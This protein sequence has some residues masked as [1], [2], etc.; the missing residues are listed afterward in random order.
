MNEPTSISNIY[1]HFTG[2]PKDV[3]W[4]LI[5]SPAQIPKNPKPDNEAFE[6]LIKII[7]S[8]KLKASATEKILEG[9]ETDKFC[10]VTDIPLKDLIIHSKT[11]G[12]VAIGFSAKRI[13]RSFF[14]PVLYLP[15]YSLPLQQADATK[16]ISIKIR[17]IHDLETFFLNCG[18]DKF[19]DGSWKIPVIANPVIPDKSWFPKYFIDHLKI[20]DFSETVGKSFYQEREWRKIKDFHFTAEDIKAIII[21]TEFLERAYDFFSNEKLSIPILTWELISKT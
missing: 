7:K 10:C 11:Y 16:K 9:I 3:D 12:N 15:K 21:P 8:K 6:I 17:A 20:T 14:N 1:W 4:H 2:S 13:H 18:F 5:T 19:K